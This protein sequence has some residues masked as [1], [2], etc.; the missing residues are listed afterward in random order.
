MAECSSNGLIDQ[1]D[2]ADLDPEADQAAVG[3]KVQSS[4]TK[5]IQ[6]C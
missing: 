5:A 4:L 3:A 6:A 1:L 2:L